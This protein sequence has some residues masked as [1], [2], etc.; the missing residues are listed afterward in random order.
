MDRGLDAVK[1][2][3]Q[4]L[5][6]DLTK[7]DKRSDGLGSNRAARRV[8]ITGATGF[9]G[10]PTVAALAADGAAISAAVRH[11]PDPPFE[12][13]VEVV[14]YPDLRQ[15]FD[16]RPLLDG[17]D[18]VIHLAGLERKLGAANA[19]YDQINHQATARL[20][21]AAAQEIGRAHV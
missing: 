10:R 11:L 1:Q 13:N 3:N 9:L 18:I 20:T 7:D 17:V 2:M 5:R 16:W 6:S 15:P 21:A 4:N 14:Q 12:A 19:A 8:L